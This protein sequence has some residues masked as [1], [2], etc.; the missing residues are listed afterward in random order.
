MWLFFYRYRVEEVPVYDS[1]EDESFSFIPETSSP[2]QFESINGLETDYTEKMEVGDMSGQELDSFN[3]VKP[4]NSFQVGGMGMKTEKVKVFDSGKSKEQD[5]QQAFYQTSEMLSRLRSNSACRNFNI[6]S[7]PT[8]K[9]KSQHIPKRKKKYAG[10]KQ[11]NTK[12]IAELF[13]SKEAQEEVRK[14]EV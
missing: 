1:A 9:K 4:H 3:T 6:G 5:M 7:G 11:F 14:Y 8:S 2:F 10:G 13:Q 12:N